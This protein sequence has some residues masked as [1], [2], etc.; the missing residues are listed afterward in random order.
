M[1]SPILKKIK[2]PPQSH[3][4]SALTTIQALQTDMNR[5]I[6]GASHYG[7]EGQSQMVVEEYAY[8]RSKVAKEVEQIKCRLE[9]AITDV[10]AMSHQLNKLQLE[11]TKVQAKVVTL[12]KDNLTYSQAMGEI[13]SDDSSTIQD[14]K[15]AQE[16]EIPDSQPDC[17][18]KVSDLSKQEGQ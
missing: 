18:A 17:Q 8:M 15:Q 2:I 14:S 5:S 4:R 11:N 1:A 16:T 9:T 13:D 12:E 6:A 7:R 3:I 10:S